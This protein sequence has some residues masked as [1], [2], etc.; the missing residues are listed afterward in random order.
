MKSETMGIVIP[1]NKNDMRELMKE[2]KETIAADVIRSAQN[3]RSFSTVDL[4]NARK[5]QRTMASMRRCN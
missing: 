5:H 4:W 2:T 1:I 3:H